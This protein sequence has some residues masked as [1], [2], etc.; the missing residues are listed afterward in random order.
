MIN[1]GPAASELLRELVRHDRRPVTSTLMGLGAFPAVGS[2][3]SL[4]MLGMHGTYEANLAMHECDVMINIGARF[5]D[6]VTGRLDAFSPQLEEDPHRYRPLSSINKNV[7][8]DL[9]DRRRCRPC[10][11]RHDPHLEGAPAAHDH[12]ALTAW[13][14]QID[15]WRGARLPRLPADATDAIKPQHAIRAAV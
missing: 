11:R 8:V 3:S 9:A 4:G 7:R 10:A 5:D 2:S 12:E 15:D 14:A 13:W 1:S 6:R